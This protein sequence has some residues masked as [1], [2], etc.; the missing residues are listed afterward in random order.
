MNARD[1]VNILLVDD[2]PSKL[3]TYEAILNTLGENLIKA[4]SGKE[5]LELLL[6]HEITVVLMDVNMPELDGIEL[7]KIIR[8][9]PRFREVA[10][11]FVSAVH[12]TDLDRLRGY[13]AGA[14]D[15][16]S[17]PVVPEILR[18]KVAVFVELYRKRREWEQLNSE[19]EL[20]VA[21]RTAELEAAAERL[22][23]SEERFRFVAETVP[24][25]VWAAGPDARLTYA[26]RRWAEYCGPATSE[27]LASWPDSALHPDDKERVV[28][29][30]DRKLQ[31]G[32]AFDI[33][34]RIRR[35]DGAYRWFVTRAVPRRNENLEVL[36]WF[37][38][39]T[40]VHD[41]IELSEK[42]READ[43][44]KDDFLAL[45]A[46]ELRNPLAP[47]RN[48]VEIMRLKLFDSDP[49]LARCR[50]V[51]ERQVNQLTR[52]VDDLLDV[53]RITRGKIKL[54]MSPLDLA[55]VVA[56]A[57]EMSRPLIDARKHELVVQLPETSLTVRGDLV[58]LTQ[59][60]ANLLNNAAKYQ[61]DGG[62]IVLSVTRDGD[63][64]TIHVVDHGVGIAAQ[65]LPTV[66]E[67]FSQVETSVSRAEGGLGIGLSLVRSIVEMHGGSVSATSAGI[68]SG[69]QFTVRLRCK[70]PDLVA[71]T[72][73]DAMAAPHV[74]PSGFEILV[75]DDNQDG[76][77]SLAMLLRA[78]GYST[79]LAHDGAS[80]L[81]AASERRP[82]A[83][84]LDIGLPGADG[85]HICQELR[86]RGFTKTLIV[87]VTGYGQDRDRQRSVEAGFDAHLVKPV[88]LNALLKILSTVRPRSDSGSGRD[89]VRSIEVAAM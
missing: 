87:A 48:A 14:V 76:A 60:I 3:L 8:E 54:Q 62:R 41:Q 35:H 77:E 72:V 4:A 79:T 45:L 24:S 5:A 85:Y 30:R 78:K 17:V 20:R 80:A 33:D 31:L 16:V 55:A 71:V 51:I 37:G 64:A 22:R 44:R 74:A 36:G 38:I 84:L 9:H 66:F 2:Q 18:A 40:D 43:R 89:S 19:L 29:E 12:L 39:T 75:V 10:I 1:R 83:I 82:D 81:A 46:H 21:E 34:A 28:A 58:R 47:L 59:V 32:E 56:D 68:G 70:E 23:A 13:E 52:L 65:T 61:D 50:N 57:V 7:A 6:K 25:I 11:I 53:S 26:N 15:Y 67:L 86:K 69:S 49:D 42:L 63:D 27:S 88:S 73:S